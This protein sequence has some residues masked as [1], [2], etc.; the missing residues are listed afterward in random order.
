M[1][2]SGLDLAWLCADWL[3]ERSLGYW[4]DMDTW[5][6]RMLARACK[7][8]PHL[9]PLLMDQPLFERC[10]GTLAVPEPFNA[11][12]VPPE[13]LTGIEQAFY[14]HLLDQHRGRIEQEFLPGNIVAEALWK[15]A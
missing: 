14:R 13:V 7:L 10:S 9:T 12:P 6:L 5:G 8:Q 11:G 2:G 3:D 15:W 1:L 4:G